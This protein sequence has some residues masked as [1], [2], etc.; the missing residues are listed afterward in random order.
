MSTLRPAPRRT[1]REFVYN[2]HWIQPG[3]AARSA[4][5]IRGSFEG[6][7]RDNSIRSLITLRGEQPRL[8]WWRREVALCK[9]LGI[10]HF[11]VQLDSRRLPMRTTLVEL[12]E[13]FD[14]A[15]T[16]FLVKCSGGQDRV[17]LAASIYLLHR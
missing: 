9:R 17:A 15:R 4:Q 3:E 5:G 16:P 11:D 7:L 2:F 1:P 13:A 12:I 6:L 10:T 8:G 14:R